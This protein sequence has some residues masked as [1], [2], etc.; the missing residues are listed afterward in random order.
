M[1]SRLDELEEQPVDVRAEQGE[2]AVAE[3]VLER[4]T[5]LLAAN[6]ASAGMTPG[7]VGGRTVILIPQREPGVEKEANR[8]SRAG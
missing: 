3:H 1:A 5:G 6:R 2:I 7:Q 4:M 8:Q